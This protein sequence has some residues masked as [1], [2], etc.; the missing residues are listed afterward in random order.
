MILNSSKNVNLMVTDNGNTTEKLFDVGEVC[1]TWF[2]NSKIT[3]K[4]E[5]EIHMIIDKHIVE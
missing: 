5:I 3:F 2:K 1:L 4:K